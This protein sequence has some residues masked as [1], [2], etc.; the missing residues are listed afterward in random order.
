M[1]SQVRLQ[2]RITLRLLS[3]RAC[4]ICQIHNRDY[5][6][7]SSRQDHGRTAHAVPS[8]ESE[9]RG[10][11]KILRLIF[12]PPAREH[13]LWDRSSSGG[14][15]VLSNGALRDMEETKW[16]RPFMLNDSPLCYCYFWQLDEK[17]ASHCSILKFWSGSS[18]LLL[19]ARGFRQ[20]ILWRLIEWQVGS[21]Q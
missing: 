4:F 2:N 16:S 17:M 5:C 19:S 7:Y 11:I 15:E 10:W 6:S 3:R 12:G 18:R 1:R 8:F 20:D 9:V 14:L 13:D 21:S